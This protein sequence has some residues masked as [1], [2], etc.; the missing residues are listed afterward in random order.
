MKAAADMSPRFVFKWRSG[1][2]RGFRK[3]LPDGKPNSIFG[4]VTHGEGFDLCA[5]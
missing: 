1:R 2:I 3:A 5:S 4:A